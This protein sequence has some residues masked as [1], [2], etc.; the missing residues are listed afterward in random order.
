ML[1]KIFLVE[2]EIVA[3][4]GIRDNVD[5]RMA[6]FEFCGEAPD[7]E[8]ALPL[9]ENIQPDVL[10]TDIKMPFMDGL[11]LC[12]IVRERMPSIKIIILTGHDEFEYAQEAVKLGVTEYL[13]K[14]VGVQD[15]HEVLGKVAAQ[16][17]R[18]RQ[19]QESLQQL[20]EQ[21]EDNLAL[22]R[23]RFLLNL[24]MGEMS[25]SEAIKI[26]QQL[27][28]DIVAKCYLVVLVRAELCRQE[29]GFNY[30]QFQQVQ[31]IASGLIE[32]N[33]D[34]FLLKKDLEEL[35][36]ILK[37][38]NGDQ[39]AQEADF[40]TE[41]IKHEVD[42]NTDCLLIRGAG[43]PK[44]RISDIPQSFAEALRSV[45][46]ELPPANLVMTNNEADKAQLLNLDKS[47]LEKF[48]KFRTLADFDEF[49]EAYLAPLSESALT[50]YLIKNYIF[51]DIVLATAKFVHSLGGV[52]DQ[53][54][55]EI[56]NVE[57]LLMNIQTVEQIKAE[58]KRMFA[59]ALAF[60]DAQVHNQHELVIH[61]AK[62][63]ID[64]YYDN[65]ELSLNTV[66]AQVNLSP[67][68]F[69]TVFSRETGETFIEYL[70]R[71][72]IEK[73]KELLRTTSLKSFEIAD[74]VGYGDPHYF[75]TVFKKNTGLTPMEFRLSA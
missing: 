23:E 38:D 20:K 24:V 25:S 54:I 18:E 4:E 26:S 59:S 74:R 37:G 31:R 42:N 27:G 49:F 65:S 55:P 44:E 12:K 21:I 16:L 51:I 1:Y 29:D 9:I 67:S 60:R 2:D 71:I 45:Q 15:L 47:T 57:T 8:M 39:L 40:L 5:W 43:S 6:G 70:T 58:T 62:E 66:A 22:R 7:G 72:R 35:V 52:V 14:P 68:H 11:Q 53:V 48:L 41:M 75:S 36:L 17:D 46:H 69:S 3:R 34:A 64:H 56:N 13:L 30:R 19:A 32:N 28:L 61:Q 63:Y 10:I 33:P 73:A 50:S